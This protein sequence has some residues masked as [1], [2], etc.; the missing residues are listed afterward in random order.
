M[1]Q[2]SMLPLAYI[3]NSHEEFKVQT[4]MMCGSDVWM[5]SLLHHS[6]V[7]GRES[8]GSR[9]IVCVCVCVC[10]CVLSGVCRGGQKYIKVALHI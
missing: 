2:Y 7:N 1:N 9:G 5:T 6:F 10:V 4:C 3:S 8:G